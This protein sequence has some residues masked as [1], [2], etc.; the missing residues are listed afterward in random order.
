MRLRSLVLCYHAVSASWDDPLA[1][2]PQTIE[3]QVRFLLRCGYRPVDAVSAL[4]NE[5]RTLHLTFDDAFCNVAAVLPA[6]RRLG[7]RVTIFACTSFADDG[8]AFYVPELRDRLPTRHEEL[9]TMPWETLRE[10]AGQGV[11]IGSH[12]VSHP[13]LTQLADADLRAELVESKQRL[14]DELGQEC[15][16]LAYPYG[17]EDARVAAAARAAGYE[18]AFSLRGRAGVLGRFA[19]PRVDVYRGDGAVRFALK[20]SPLRA[21]ARAARAALGGR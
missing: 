8:R 14:E 17:D 20:V 4:A 11:E 15:R 18:A 3:R 5:R 21:P 7:V 6:L 1:V 12:S 16:V 10:V 9:M 13:H 2:A 19:L